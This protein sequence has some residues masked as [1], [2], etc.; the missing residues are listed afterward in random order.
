MNKEVDKGVEKEKGELAHSA[1]ISS[2][3]IRSPLFL[4]TSY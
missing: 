4:L 1:S 2:S 3:L